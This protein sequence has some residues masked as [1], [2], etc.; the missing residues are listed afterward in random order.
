MKHPLLLLLALMVT[1]LANAEASTSH[2]TS[3]ST[4]LSD[5]CQA[6]PIKA[7]YEVST[8][9]KDRKVASYPFTFYRDATHALYVYPDEGLADLWT[10]TQN[11]QLELSRNFSTAKRAIEYTSADLRNVHNR[12]HWDKL[13]GVIDLQGESPVS[14]QSADCKSIATYKD[15]HKDIRYYNRLKLPASMTFTNG[16]KRQTY[17]LKAWAYSH[18][19]QQKL[20][21]YRRYDAM[22]FADIGDNE[23]DPFVS[24]MITMGFIE[25]AEP[26][27]TGDQGYTH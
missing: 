18:E 10:L 14:Q 22:D 5:P 13:F 11:N 21:I 23:A 25:H 16:D 15:A 20:K 24:K 12:E 26:S 9:I 3:N 19:L 1:P 6:K 8:F 27:H 4:T 7:N 17:T 2:L